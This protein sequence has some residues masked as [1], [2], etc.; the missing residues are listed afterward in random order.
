[1]AASL[2][3]VGI[4]LAAL[5]LAGY[6]ASRV[7]LSVIPAYIVAGVLVGPQPPTE[8][9][10][11]SLRLVD[12]GEF[13]DLAA[14]LG[15]VLLLFF[16][17]L[18]FSVGQLLAD[19]RRIVAAGSVDFLVNFGAGVA[20]GALFGRTLLETLLIAGV[21][22]VSSSAVVTK[23]IIDTGWVADP[24]AEPILGT[25]VFEDV[26]IAVYLALVAALLTGT[27]DPL[28]AAAD[29]G[30]AFAD[31]GT[32]AVLAWY[33]TDLVERTFDLPSD[34]LFL[35]HVLGATTLV[36]GAALATGVSEAVA[37][38]FVGTGFSQTAH[39]E[40]I[41]DVVAPV[42]DLFAAVFFF[43]I[44]LTTDVTVL[45]GVAPLLVVAVALTTGTKLISGTLGGRIY[46]LDATRSLRTGI[47]LVPRA[48]FSLV[49]AT[50]AAGAGG[51][52]DDVIPAFTVGYVLAMSV[53]G[54]VLIQHADR[55]TAV[56]A[57]VAPGAD[58]RR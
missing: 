15:I 13:V 22:Y 35:L 27:G 10:G 16:L 37:A 41:E 33:G 2:V 26:V 43:A 19:R 25:L 44:G 24:E 14:D 11:V 18:E 5:A 7:S 39:V 28:D 32:V 58:N 6:A 47:G 12:P 55:V 40:R 51:T 3:Q 42:R 56:L 23:S 17:G 45:S 52:L 21:V 30:R 9:L 57:P 48:E 36:A 53:L 54:T 50:V 31:L 38:F 4:A 49:I 20:L 29:V 34:E 46:D 1:M 8:L